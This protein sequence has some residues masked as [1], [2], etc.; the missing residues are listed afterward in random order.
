MFPL[1]LAAA[2]LLGAGGKPASK[3]AKIQIQ[4]SPAESVVYVDGK[5]RGTGAR[6]LTVTVA[7]GKHLIRVKHKKDEHQDVVVVKAGELKSFSWVFE[8]DRQ[9]AAPPVESLPPEG[10]PS[11]PTTSPPSTEPSPPSPQGPTEG[12]PGGA[13]P[14]PAPSGPP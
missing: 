9:P 14:E 12:G 1:A 6:P 4:V 3:K 7:P 2:L 5:K 11:S 13:P 10:S 8:D